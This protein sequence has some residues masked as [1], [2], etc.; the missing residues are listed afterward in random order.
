MASVTVKVNG[1]SYPVICGDGEEDHLRYLAEFVDKKVQ[2]LSKS[3]ANVSEAQLMLMAS[4]LIADD[5]AQAYETIDQLK[6]DGSSNG[7]S[8]P[9][10]WLEK[11]E[12]I[13]EK[14]ES[15]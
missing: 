6:A 5:L 8:V 3:V 9:E 10:V 15:A 11:L 14:L 12:A 13:A 1:R 2:D 7:V 4:L